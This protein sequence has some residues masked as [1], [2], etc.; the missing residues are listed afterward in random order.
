MPISKELRELIASNT[1]HFEYDNQPVTGLRKEI[2]LIL[3]LLLKMDK[4][5]DKLHKEHDIEIDR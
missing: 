1:F 3:E 2:I 4:K 5:I